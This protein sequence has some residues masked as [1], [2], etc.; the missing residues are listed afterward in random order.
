M[1]INKVRND[2]K[3]KLW[4]GIAALSAIT[5]NSAQHSKDCIR[6]AIDDILK[7]T[8]R[9]IKGV[10]L[11]ELMAALD[12]LCIDYKN[13]YNFNATNMRKQSLARFLH[14]FK[15]NNGKLYLILITGHFIVTDGN[16]IIDSLRPNGDALYD[17]PCIEEQILQVI[18]IS[19]NSLDNL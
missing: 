10:Y 6:L 13:I 3:G 19:D 2:L 18:E 11:T 1:K 4:C 17:H 12:Y 9:T 15:P 7:K 16:V 8:G 14:G 5:G